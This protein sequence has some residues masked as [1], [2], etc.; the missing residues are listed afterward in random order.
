MSLLKG[1]PFCCFCLVVLGAMQ[2]TTAATVYLIDFGTPGAQTTGVDQNNNWWNN[3]TGAEAEPEVNPRS[4]TLV[5]TTTAGGAGISM[6]YQFSTETDNPNFN[7]KNATA[8]S[9]LGNL[10]NLGLM[11]VGSATLD[12]IWSNRV[13]DLTFTELDPSLEYSF[14]LFAYRDQPNRTSTYQVLGSVASTIETRTVNATAADGGYIIS[15]HG[16]RPD[17]NGNIV[18]R[19]SPGTGGYAYLSTLQL[20]VTPEPGR[21]MLLLVGVAAWPLRR[22]RF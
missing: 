22:R 21:A 9:S 19:V 3:L 18:V 14:D 17:E 1:I 11:N 13:F 7:N 12:A 6:Q 10:A 2:S 20:T 4:G 16:Y 5:L 15:F 8:H